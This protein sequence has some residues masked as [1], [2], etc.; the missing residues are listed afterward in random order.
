MFKF[1]FDS[2]GILRGTQVRDNS[3]TSLDPNIILSPNEVL[4]QI[5]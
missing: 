4:T 1:L 2:F 5:I 3:W